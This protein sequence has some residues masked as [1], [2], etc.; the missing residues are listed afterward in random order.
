MV[1]SPRMK[2]IAAGCRSHWFFE[3]I[4]LGKLSVGIDLVVVVLCFYLAGI[5]VVKNTFRFRHHFSTTTY[6]A[7]PFFR[8]LF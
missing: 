6:T 1:S 4:K 5:V 8:T 2:N 7:V 3:L